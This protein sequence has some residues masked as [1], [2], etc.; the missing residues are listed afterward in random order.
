MY[1]IRNS[2]QMLLDNL[3]KRDLDTMALQFLSSCSIYYPK[4]DLAIEIIRLF[5]LFA[6]KA[7]RI[8]V[9]HYR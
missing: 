5:L 4:I 3:N 6:R 1:E 9:S 8:T 2:E 7:R